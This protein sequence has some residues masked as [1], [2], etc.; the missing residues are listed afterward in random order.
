[1]KLNKLALTLTV[2]ALLPTFASASTDEIVASFERDLHREPVNYTVAIA[3]EADQLAGIFNAALYGT[4]DQ[5][6]ASFERDLYRV[7]T[8]S[9][10]VIVGEADPLTIAIN[11]VLWSEMV[12]PTKHAALANSYRQVR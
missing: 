4:T 2:A 6:L 8:T 9:S 5:V 3:G 7:P 1:M 12:K 10:A 11:A